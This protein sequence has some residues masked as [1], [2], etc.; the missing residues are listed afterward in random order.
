MKGRNW[1][2][3][4][5]LS[6][7]LIVSS[8]CQSPLES[9]SR[10]DILPRVTD[11]RVDS[12]SGGV[13]YLSW[14]TPDL[15]QS[16]G[17][18]Y[19]YDL[20][21]STESIEVLDWEPANIVKAVPITLMPGKKENWQIAGLDDNA[22]YFF[23]IKIFDDRG[24]FTE[25]SNIAPLEDFVIDLDDEIMLNFRWQIGIDTGDIYY[26]DILRMD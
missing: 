18:L 8:R 6:I 24:N 1:I 7:I 21:Y 17:A 4:S 5:F 2:C 19:R 9:P 11:L 23:G 26:S 12:L 10:S 14:T 15:S 13:A 22:E 25:V 20:R 3:Y 16:M